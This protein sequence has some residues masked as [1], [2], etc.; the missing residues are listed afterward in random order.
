MVMA[1]LQRR[2]E[3]VDWASMVANSDSWNSESCV[4][5]VRHLRVVFFTGLSAEEEVS[6]QTELTGTARSA[7]I[8]VEHF[9]RH[10]KHADL[11]HIIPFNIS[12]DVNTLT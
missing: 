4:N 11:S 9:F 6:I 10:A 8:Q 5:D 3:K 2:V 12:K 1:H 7:C